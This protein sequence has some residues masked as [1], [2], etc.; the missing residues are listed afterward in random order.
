MVYTWELE[1][2]WVWGGMIIYHGVML[3]VELDSDKVST[4]DDGG[5]TM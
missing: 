4:R 3:M 1:V 2:E 5:S